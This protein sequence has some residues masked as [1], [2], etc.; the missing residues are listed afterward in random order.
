MKIENIDLLKE[1]CEQEFGKD[2]DKALDEI[3]KLTKALPNNM[4]GTYISYPHKRKIYCLFFYILSDN[5]VLFAPQ[6]NHIVT[7]THLEEDK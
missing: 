3:V 2:C 5:T 1:F 4:R 7:R 6:F